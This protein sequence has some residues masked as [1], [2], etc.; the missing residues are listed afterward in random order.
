MNVPKTEQKQVFL[1]SYSQIVAL[2]EALKIVRQLDLNQ[3]SVS[4]IGNL[5]EDYINDDSGLTTVTD[6]LQLFFKGIL[7]GSTDFDT[8]YNPE[9]GRLFVVGFLVS[10]FKN[11]V[12]KRAIGVLSGGPYGILRGLGVKE[13]EAVSSV[14]KLNDGTY[15]LVA[16]G[17]RRTIDKLQK[18]LTN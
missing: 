17:D 9:L 8:F 6:E 2:A 10:T 4:V 18:E 16:R 14:K 13:A 5:G 11:T 1:K 12:G 7:G 15:L 3:M